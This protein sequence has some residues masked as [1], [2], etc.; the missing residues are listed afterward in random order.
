MSVIDIDHLKQ[1]IGGEELQ[2]DLACAAPLA[3][4]AALLDHQDPPWPKDALPP[5]GHWLFFLPR[6][7]QSLIDA[8]GHPRRGGL[9]PPVPLPRRMWAGGSLSFHTPIRIGG[10]IRRLT[11]VEDVS[12]KSGASGDMVFVVLE[13]EVSDADGNLC[14]RERQDIVYRA[15][16]PVA[17]S[18]APATPAESPAGAPGGA[19]RRT[20]APDPVLLFRFSAL[21]FNA[22]RIHYDRDYARDIEAYPGLV[23]HGPLTATLLIDHFLRARPDAEI[24][25]F[26]FRAQRPLFD[27]AAFQLHLEPGA[28]EHELWATGPDGQVAMKASVRTR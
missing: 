25:A 22:H 16:S 28:D 7:Q 15:A 3:G 8:D 18:P 10:A 24:A 27:T 11:R 26:R 19:V 1:W 14:V 20:I 9:L 4:L 23:V 2:A 12:L 6:A 13:H 5:L 17:A 21:T